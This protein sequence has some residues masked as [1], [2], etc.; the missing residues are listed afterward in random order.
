MSSIDTTVILL[1][2]RP[3]AKSSGTLL[4]LPLLPHR[5]PLKSLPS[6]IWT[7]IFGFAFKSCATGY[8]S[9]RFI[10]R[11]AWSSITICKAF[12]EIVLP[13]LYSSVQISQDYTLVRFYNR[14]HIADQKWDSIRRIP[15]SSPGRWVQK[16]DL[17]ELVFEGQPQALSL[18]S[19]LTQLFPL[20]PFL[21]SLS[22][23]P[24]FV[25]SRR[26][27]YSLAQREGSVNLRSISGLSYLPP[28]TP[29]PDEDPFVQ[30]LRNS[31]NLETFVVVGQGLDPTELE[32]N[33][34]GLS[35]EMPSISEFRP[36]RLTKLRTLTILSLH[37]SP[38]VLALL[39]SPLPGLKKLTV[40]PYDDIPYPAS[41]ISEFIKIH[42]AG[43]SSLLLFTPKSWPTRLH[44]SP[45][46]ILV[47]C[48]NLNHLSLE[49]PLPSLTLTERH[50]LRILSIPRPKADFWREL[51]TLFHRL[52]GL[53]IL[54]IRDIRWLRKGVSTMAQGAGVQ[55]EMLEWKRRLERR[56][57]LLVDADWRDQA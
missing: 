15:Y 7:E 8:E 12:S 28:P 39:H 42:G 46:G 13:L 14:L 19:H 31:P 55:G 43:L 53:A 1:R 26:A 38:L 25:L 3:Y 37:S 4:L 23:N 6:E 33:F 40:T 35:Y 22:V 2:P 51:E 52:P 36:L 18:D 49:S 41:L 24:S 47:H 9:A 20:V 27:L 48:P 57:I 21:T 50:Q 29:I 54:R 17:S 34:P 10:Y 16:L 45:S 44:P 32:F 5:K 11:W 30:L 56:R